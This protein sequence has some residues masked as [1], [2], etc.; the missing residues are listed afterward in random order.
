M[1]LAHGVGLTQ[2]GKHDAL[3]GLPVWANRDY[4][5]WLYVS[6]KITI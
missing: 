5:F 4:L 3:L 1:S 6:G 2:W